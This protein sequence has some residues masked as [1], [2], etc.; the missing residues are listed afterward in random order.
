MNPTECSIDFSEIEARPLL[1]TRNMSSTQMRLKDL[2]ERGEARFNIRASYQRPNRWKIEAKNK[3]IATIMAK[4]PIPELLAYEYDPSNEEDKSL[5]HQGCREEIIDGHHRTETI[6]QFMKSDPIVFEDST[7]KDPIPKMISW[8]VTQGDKTY[9]LFYQN[10]RANEK[11]ISKKPKKQQQYYCFFTPELRRRFDDYELRIVRIVE[12][13][14]LAQRREI[15]TSLQGGEDI[16]NS[17]KIKNLPSFERFAQ[18]G[19]GDSML[20]VFYPHCSKQAKQYYTQWL[21]RLYEMFKAHKTGGNVLD[22]Y[23]TNDT[24][25][26]KRAEREDTVIDDETFDGFY[27]MFQKFMDFL[28]SRE[29]IFNPTQIFALFHH[30]FEYRKVVISKDSLKE[31]AKEGQDKTEFWEGNSI[32]QSKR[33][34]YYT[35]VKFELDAL[36]NEELRNKAL[37]NKKPRKKSL[38]EGTICEM[39]GNPFDDTGS[40]ISLHSEC[41]ENCDK[42]CVSSDLSEFPGCDFSVN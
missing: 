26:K 29:V 40:D 9:Y 5:L 25:Y 10:T 13:L 35:E 23:L 15:F 20:T 1:L 38:E 27:E 19:C 11:W 42:S 12:R 21:F 36:R 7:A 31:F 30:L 22:A 16:K 3:L 14:T 8:N 17:D 2:Q 37:R 32:P 24:T 18:S 28:D 34:D 6:L 33:A 4:G 39:C 41:V